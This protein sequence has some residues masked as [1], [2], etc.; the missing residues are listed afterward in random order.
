M[1]KRWTVIWFFIE[2]E[3]GFHLRGKKVTQ[4]LFFYVKNIKIIHPLSFGNQ[5]IVRNDNN[6]IKLKFK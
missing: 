6:Y 1:Q 2:K 3:Y 4:K 5:A